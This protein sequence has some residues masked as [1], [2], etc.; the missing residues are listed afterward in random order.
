M[1]KNYDPNPSYGVHTIEITLQ[2]WEYIGHIRQK[3][4]GNCKGK[5]M[6]DF[7]FDCE[8]EFPEND[9]NLKY[10]ED[11]GYFSA[12]LKDSE[13]NTLEVEGDSRDFNKMIVKMEIV[14]FQKDRDE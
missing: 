8:D 9:C 14:D 13:G 10:H 7:D 1:L 11:W 4:N 5:D 3:V 6:L 2:S 12:T